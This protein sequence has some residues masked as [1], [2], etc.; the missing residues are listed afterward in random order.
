LRDERKFESVEELKAEIH[1]DIAKAGRFF[2]RA[3]A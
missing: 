3:G 2:R 1:R